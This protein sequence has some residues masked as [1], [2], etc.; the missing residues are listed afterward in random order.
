[1][2]PERR[3]EAR[4][5]LTPGHTWKFP[6]RKAD[7]HEQAFTE[8]EI[9]VWFVYWWSSEAWASMILPSERV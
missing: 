7:T 2:E 1:M 6:H 8:R 3:P 9:C 4:S 5:E